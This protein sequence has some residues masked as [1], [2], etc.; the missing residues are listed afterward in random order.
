[1]NQNHQT[2]RWKDH[3][4]LWKKLL[5]VCNYPASCGGYRYHGSGGKVFL[6]YHVTS[7][8]WCSKGCVT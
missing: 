6:T 1:M 3:V 2:T 7:H 8:D 5:I 4:T